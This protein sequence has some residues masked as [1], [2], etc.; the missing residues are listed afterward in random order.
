MRPLCLDLFCK[1][2]GAGMGYFQAGFDVI[3]FDVERQPK[4]P[5]TF[6]QGDA[7]DVL[8]SLVGGRTGRTNEFALIHASPPCQA[9]TTGGR[10]R[11]RESIARPRTTLRGIDTEPEPKPAEPEGVAECVA[12]FVAAIEALAKGR[13]T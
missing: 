6:I 12:E 7:L 4:Y 2:G 8:R 11:A 5:F 10:V 9:Y 3:G 1:Q 13:T